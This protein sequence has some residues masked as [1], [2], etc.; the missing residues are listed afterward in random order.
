M[1]LP[2]KIE[3]RKESPDWAFLKDKMDTGL[4]L[5][6]PYEAQWVLNLAFLSGKQ[7]SF[8]NMMSHSLHELTKVPG[9]IFAVDNIILPKWKR[10]VS[11]LIKGQPRISVVPNSTQEEDIAAAKLGKKV[12]E[13]YYH[14]ELMRKKGR[15]LATWMFT[16]GN[17]YLS[18]YWDRKKGPHEHGQGTG[19]DCL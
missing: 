14:K 10:Q 2:W 9:Q 15:Q 12:L 3:R 6:R 8:F 1:R 18:D 17:A 11:N 4:E 7:Y 13:Y 19:E 16:C 5:R